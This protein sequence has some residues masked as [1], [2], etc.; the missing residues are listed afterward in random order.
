MIGIR[1]KEVLKLFGSSVR[2]KRLQYGFSQSEL[3]HQC[4]ID[5]RQIGRIERGEVNTTISTV[6]AIARALEVEVAYLFDFPLPELT[7]EED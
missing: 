4:Q 1:D 5:A 6:F 3:A 2:Q 7:K